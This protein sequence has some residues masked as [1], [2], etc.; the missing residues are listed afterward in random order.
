VL[1][2]LKQQRMLQ[3]NELLKQYENKGDDFSV[4]SSLEMKLWYTTV[5]Q[6][7]NRSLCSSNTK[8]HHKSGNPRHHHQWE[9]CVSPLGTG[10]GLSL[11]I[12]W[13]GDP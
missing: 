7:Q 3:C 12:S 5:D 2:E 1:P 10:N 9:K 11:C 8:I 4:K 13:N 6:S